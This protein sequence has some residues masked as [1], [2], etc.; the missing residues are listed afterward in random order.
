MAV[1]PQD[2]LGN[3]KRTTTLPPHPP[4]LNHKKDLPFPS[5]LCHYPREVSRLRLHGPLQL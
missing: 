4:D 3:T 2:G 5:Q 1:F